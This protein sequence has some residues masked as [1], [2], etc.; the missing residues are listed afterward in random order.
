MNTRFETIEMNIRKVSHR[1]S[2]FLN[3]TNM[4]KCVAYRMHSIEKVC[5][6]CVILKMMT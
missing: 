4:T 6:G 5:P 1:D 2:R 3:L